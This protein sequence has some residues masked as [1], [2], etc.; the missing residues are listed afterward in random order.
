MFGKKTKKD[1]PSPE[2]VS[3]EES[4][5]GDKKKKGGKKG[6]TKEIAPYVEPQP[7]VEKKRKLSSIFSKKLLFVFLVLTSLGIASFVVY[8]IYF[9]KKVDV[10]GYVQQELPNVTIAEE[11]IKFTYDFIPELYN[12][13]ILFNSE[14][15]LIENEIKRLTAIGEK[16]PDQIKISEKEMKNWEKEKNKLKQTYEKIGKR[17]E[18]LY[19]SYRVNQEAGAL[20]IQEQK[21]DITQSAKDAL[22]PVLEL[23]RRLKIV[24]KETIP[25]GFV[26]GTI[27]KMRKKI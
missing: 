15:I 9:V 17:A 22:A 3:A 8:K 6:D 11:V 2:P 14:V 4:K 26:Q 18:A 27:Y 20:Q 5:K 21:N 19:V 1:P 25:E 24:P 12:S 7:S 23:T 16:F 13:I 10:S